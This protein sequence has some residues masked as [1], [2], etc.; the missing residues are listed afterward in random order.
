M[1]APLQNTLYPVQGAVCAA[2]GY[3]GWMRGLAGVS[4]LSSGLSCCCLPLRVPW[5]APGM[6]VEACPTAWGDPSSEAAAT[7]PEGTPVVESEGSVSWAEAPLLFPELPELCPPPPFCEPPALAPPCWEPPPEP[8]A[9]LPL[10]F[11]ELLLP[12]ILSE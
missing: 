6:A 10:P 9:W 12:L 4:G 1:G 7:G 3:R 11:A 8:L 5:G 2:G